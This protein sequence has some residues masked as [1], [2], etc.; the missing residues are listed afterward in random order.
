MALAQ[1]SVFSPFHPQWKRRPAERTSGSVR[2]ALSSE[3]KSRAAI[4]GDAP[5]ITI[6][7]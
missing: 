6:T 7:V 1:C 3:T 5:P 4:A 2:E